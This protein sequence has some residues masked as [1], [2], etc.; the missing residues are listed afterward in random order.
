MGGDTTRCLRHLCT[1][2]RRRYKHRNNFDRLL[3]TPATQG[4]SNITSLM[5][6]E[7]SMPFI[8]DIVMRLPRLN[9]L[10]LYGVSKSYKS[11][12]PLLESF[13]DRLQ[14][15][16]LLVISGDMNVG[17]IIRT[18]PMLQKLVIDCSSE[19]RVETYHGDHV[20]HYLE[21]IILS[22][23]N[24][25]LCSK[26]I[27]ESILQSPNLREINLDNID[28]LSDDVLFKVLACLRWGCTPFSKVVNFSLINCAKITAEPIIHWLSI[29]SCVLK[30]INISNCPAIKIDE[31]NTAAEKYPKILHMAVYE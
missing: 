21:T 15:L 6:T 18:C 9:T 12:L 29:D 22:Y 16:T 8:I 25:Q 7:Q 23:T 5:V 19:D 17:D 24:E 26:E 14:D 13:G 31:L 10:I 11:L 1:E 3:R 4:I 30:Y 27:L 2:E 20:L 28:A